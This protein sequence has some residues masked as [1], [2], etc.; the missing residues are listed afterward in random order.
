MPYRLRFEKK[1]GWC[2]WLEI[3]GKLAVIGWKYCS[4]FGPLSSWFLYA[5][6]LPLMWWSCTDWL[7]NPCYCLCLSVFLN[8]RSSSVAALGFDAPVL[9]KCAF[10]NQHLEALCTIYRELQPCTCQNLGLILRKT[11]SFRVLVALL[12]CIFLNRSSPE[13][14]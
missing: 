6:F 11:S 7:W 8:D 3:C 13:L 14:V 5:Y 2:D 4:D 10:S 9:Q 12:F 1:L